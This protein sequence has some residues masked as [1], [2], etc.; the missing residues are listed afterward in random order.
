VYAISTRPF[1]E[2][3]KKKSASKKF[4]F[5]LAPTLT[6]ITAKASLQEE[7]VPQLEPGRELARR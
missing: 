7:D 6:L 4:P 2:F 1:A 3:L 5:F